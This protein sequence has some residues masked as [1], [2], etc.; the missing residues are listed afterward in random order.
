MMGYERK[1]CN[2]LSSI[3]VPAERFQVYGFLLL[4]SLLRI[5]RLTAYAEG[6]CHRKTEALFH[7]CIYAM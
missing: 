4:P 2:V 1:I 5:S 7:A 6:Q 3:M